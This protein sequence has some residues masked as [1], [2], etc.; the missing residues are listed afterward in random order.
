MVLAK[1]HL[2]PLY[3]NI[4]YFYY[5][6]LQSK[7]ISLINPYKYSPQRYKDFFLVDNTSRTS[8]SID[9]NSEVPKVIYLFWTGDNPISPNRKAAI[10]S[11]KKNSMVDVK[12]I[13]PENL[14]SYILPESPLHPA[15][16]N[17]SLIHKADYLRTYFM[18]HYGGG[19]TDIK[20]C[21]NSWEEAFEQLNYSEK[22]ILGYQ[23]KGI[24]GV[25]KTGHSI[26][27]D[28][29]IY[30]RNLI[31]NGAYISRPK[32]PF[33]YDWYNEL[34]NRMDKYEKELSKYPGNTY[35]DNDGYPIPWSNI[36]GQI[37]HPLCLKYSDKLIIN[38]S[39]CPSFKNYR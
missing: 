17:L 22:Y 15:F 25:C 33:T 2:R 24:N 9:L 20:K 38:N 35:G 30:W 16:K 5:N 6:N 14:D 1:K 21:K 11:I 18:H 27:S 13:T 36:L 4:V 8:I 37:F 31:G 3:V 10:E 12:L 32:T 19:Y 29:R 23:E 26:D 28:L 7:I 34:I 39:I